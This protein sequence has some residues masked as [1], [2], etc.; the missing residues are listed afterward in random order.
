M[1][2]RF[3]LV[4]LIAAVISIEIGFNSLFIILLLLPLT[5][6]RR[7][8]ERILYTSREGWYTNAGLLFIIGFMGVLSTSIFKTNDA[9]HRWAEKQPFYTDLNHWMASIPYNDGSFLWFRELTVTDPFYNI[10]MIG[11]IGI[12]LI[13]AVYAFATANRKTLV[14]LLFVNWFVHGVIALPFYLFFNVHEVWSTMGYN[15][16]HVPYSVKNC[17]PS[18]HTSV[19]FSCMLLARRES[20]SFA[21]IWGIYG[22]LIIFTTLYLRIH[23]VIDVLGGLVLGWALYTLA[24]KLA[25]YVLVRLERRRKRAPR[26]TAPV[27]RTSI[28]ILQNRK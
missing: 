19:A 26:T 20:R 5:V 27:L 1:Y 7:V 13:Y 12:Y 15:W 18:L 23:W 25:P 28:S 3:F 2:P 22:A 14:R 17:F 9:L 4:L 16:G 21:A 10:Y 11:F 6:D 8:K 24:N